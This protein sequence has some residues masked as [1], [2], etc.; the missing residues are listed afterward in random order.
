MPPAV[1]ELTV[2]KWTNIPET[3]KWRKVRGNRTIFDGMLEEIISRVHSLDDKLFIKWRSTRWNLSRRENISCIGSVKKHNLLFW[4]P[5]VSVLFAGLER[6]G[7]TERLKAAKGQE[8]SHKKDMI[9]LIL[10]VMRI[11]G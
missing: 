6:Q 9:F 11:I 8:L 10:T 2:L 1:K 7:H 4:R 3:N 5:E